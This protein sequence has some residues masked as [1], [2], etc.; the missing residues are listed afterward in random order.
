MDIKIKFIFLTSFS[1]IKK[2]YLRE[3]GYRQRNLRA[4]LRILVVHQVFE[5]FQPQYQLQIHLVAEVM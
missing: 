1:L 4:A 5:T 3:T 2:V